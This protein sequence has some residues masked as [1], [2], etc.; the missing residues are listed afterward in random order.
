[1]RLRGG[2]EVGTVSARG[3]HLV[4][5]WGLLVA[6]LAAANLASFLLYRSV[7]EQLDQQ[8]GARLLSIATTAAEAIGAARFE[9]LASDSVGGAVQRSV[10]AELSRIAATNELDNVAVV[11][12][13]GRS[14]LDLRLSAARGARHPLLDLEPELRA[15]LVSGV[16]QT[17]RLIQVE[18]LRGEYLKTG[19]AP[20]ED[21]SG[22]I[23]GGIAVEGGSE[24]FRVLP[25]LRTQLW[26]STA[27]G[28]AAAAILGLLF[29]RHVRALIQ[30]EERLRGSAALVAIGQLSAI[31]AHEIR[32]PLAIIRSRA[33][34]VGAKIRQ[35]RDTAEVLDW[36]DAIPREI[37]RL[38][39]IL[40]NY[41][42][43]ARPQELAAGE[44]SAA[45]VFD[46]TI[47]LLSA[48]A[49]IRGV[50][51]SSETESDPTASLRVP[52]GARP[53]QQ[54]ILNLALNGL[55]AMPNGGRLS[56]RARRSKGAVVLEVEDTGE[57][58]DDRAREQALEPFFTTKPTG[59]GLGLTL[60]R[61]LIEA[62]GGSVE[63][64]S[65]PG[66]GTTVRL[67]LPDSR[68]SA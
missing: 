13:E 64:Q 29:L 9:A 18:G 22:R 50:R 16:P 46:D 8:L 51:L 17:T 66:Q 4:V 67:S 63:L 6:L 41:L 48:D 12:R 62:R 45:Q 43:L 57:G 5:L 19:F 2:A 39:H 30:L 31:V 1:M 26:G 28:G 61:T 34:R 68:R 24:F 32:N 33:E 56:L 11:D 15:T 53:L 20:F 52:M 3:R 36:F 59:S 58:M 54:V 47:A 55:Q 14:I 49:E 27:L 44:C 23:V 7:R 10:A 35:G 38:D 60:V 37:D 21:A 42:S 65:I 40:T 25:A